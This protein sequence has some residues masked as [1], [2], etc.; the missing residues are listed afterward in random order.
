[1]AVKNITQLRLSVQCR[2]M[3]ACD[4]PGN[5]RFLLGSSISNFT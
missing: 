3:L 1:M 5:S 4:Q 2:F